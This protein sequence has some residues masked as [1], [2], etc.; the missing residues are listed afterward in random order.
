MAH[1]KLYR[2]SEHQMIGGVAGGFAEFFDLDPT[3]IRIAFVLLAFMG[4][5][6]I[7][8]YLACLLIMPSRKGS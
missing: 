2:S 5:T 1:Q 7:L 4:G 6:G 8:L 3:L